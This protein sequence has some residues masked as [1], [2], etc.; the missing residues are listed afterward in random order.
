M[1]LH[2]VGVGGFVVCVLCS[3]VADGQRSLLVALVYL[4]CIFGMA[5]VVCVSRAI[6]QSAHVAAGLGW[7][8]V[9][10]VRVRALCRLPGLG[11]W[12]AAVLAVRCLVA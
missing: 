1:A 2:G 7:C 10:W 12:R 8:G 5:S 9:V 3:F 4:L 11:Y 6:S